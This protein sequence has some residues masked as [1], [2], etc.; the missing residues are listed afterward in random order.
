MK[1]NY[2]A[3]SKANGLPSWNPH[4]QA[5]CVSFPLGCLQSQF[6][7]P[8]L[9]EVLRPSRQFHEKG[10]K[11]GRCKLLPFW[12]V[13]TLSSYILHL[14]QWLQMCSK[15]DWCEKYVEIVF[16]SLAALNGSWKC[17]SLSQSPEK[18][19]ILRQSKYLTLV[20]LI[21]L[22]LLK[23]G[24]IS[25]ATKQHFKNIITF[26]KFCSKMLKWD[27][28]MCQNNFLSFPVVNEL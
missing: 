12:S 7:Y 28:L 4:C 27:I 19:I 9:R 14:A 24:S 21:S 5:L 3:G 10:S 16:F 18:I 23:Y 2:S 25:S 8:W 1:F 22:L 13:S 20:V 17:W 26:P 6:R 11:E 15:G